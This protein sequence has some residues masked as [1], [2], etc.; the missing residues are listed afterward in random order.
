MS[1]MIKTILVFLGLFFI[2]T[3]LE[4]KSIGMSVRDGN[5]HF[6]EGDYPSSI[7]EYEAALEKNPESDIIHFN[8]GT[9]SYKK[10]DYDAAS[11]N[12]QK[13]L[14]TDDPQLREKAHYNLGNT[15][16]QAGIK[17]ENDNLNN[18]ISLLEKSLTQY[19]RALEL[20]QKDE[21]AKDNQDFVKK[22]LERLKKKSKEQQ[23][24][25]DN[26]QQQKQQ[27][28]SQKEEKQKQDQQSQDNKTEEQ[29]ENQN[30]EKQS[31]P[32]QQGQEKKEDSKE[33]SPHQQKQQ[34]SRQQEAQQK[35]QQNENG[36]TPEALT[37]KEAQMLLENYQ[38]T[39]EPKGLLQFYKS[40]GKSEPVLKD[41]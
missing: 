28:S 22:E 34:G 35:D 24:K 9:A 37:E 32:S 3:S 11:E 16:Y 30:Q 4:A 13:S 17:H 29:K 7:K 8:L 39:E 40:S 26:Q 20:D 14:L 12:L 5:K 15:F 27:E 41:W 23:K 38:Q 1:R 36:K 10:G 31:Q 19:E 25:Q 6:K 21:D 18:A 2:S 33:Q